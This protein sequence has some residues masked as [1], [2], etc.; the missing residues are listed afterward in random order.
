MEPFHPTKHGENGDDWEKS[1]Y[2]RLMYEKERRRR[3]AEDVSASEKST[4]GKF[5]FYLALVP[6]I[7]PLVKYINT[8][9]HLEFLLGC[10]VLSL[11]VYRISR[12]NAKNN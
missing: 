7:L 6:L 8:D 12:Q 3:E 2:D 10:L 4:W 5:L 9:Q 11:V 1:V